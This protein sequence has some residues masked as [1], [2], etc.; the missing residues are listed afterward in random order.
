MPTLLP[1]L[2]HARLSATIVITLISTNAASG[3]SGSLFSSETGISGTL[4][5]KNDLPEPETSVPSLLLYATGT[6][7]KSSAPAEEEI[8]IDPNDY[9]DMV[10]YNPETGL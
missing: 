4:S 2:V 5:V 6:R 7:E 10:S 9:D 1:Q 3:G 8:W